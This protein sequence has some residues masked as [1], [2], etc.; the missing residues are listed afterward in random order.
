MNQKVA[1]QCLWETVFHYAF[2]PWCW[3]RLL[4]VSW[5]ARRSNQ[6]VLVEISPEYSSEGLIP[7]LKLQYFGHLM[8][9]ADS[10]EKTPTLA[11]TEDRRGR[12]RTSWL[13]GIINSMDMSLSTLREIVEDR[14][15]W[16]AAVCGV[17]NSQTWLSDQQQLHSS[18]WR[19]LTG[20]F[21]LTVI[22]PQSLLHVNVYFF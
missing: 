9:R 18:L 16:H 2:K 4:R 20:C 17:T 21:P 5:T 12:Q 10:L 19:V 1:V 13:D 8:W 11:K 14:G 22:L 7:K 6:S 3:R 15:A